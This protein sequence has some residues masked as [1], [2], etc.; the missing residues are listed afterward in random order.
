[1]NISAHT[2]AIDTFIPMIRSLSNVLDKGAQL[3]GA[4]RFDVAVLVKARLAPDM[5]T[6]QQQVQLACHHAKDATARLTG[7]E[8]IPPALVDETFDELK[9]RL[10]ATIK[11]LQSAAATAFE[12][13]EDRDIVIPL[14]GG[15]MAFEMKGYQFLRD[16]ALPHF[17]FHVVTAYDILRHKGVDI[18]KRDYVGNVGGYIRPSK[19]AGSSGA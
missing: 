2:L 15:A 9:S 14:P 18:G 10:Q 16:W 5:Y 6:L 11:D 19:Q 3:A 13:A 12:G 8:P 4:K 7:N 17:Y 1:M